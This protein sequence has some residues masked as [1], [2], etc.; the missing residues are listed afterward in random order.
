MGK[1][2]LFFSDVQKEEKEEERRNNKVEGC[3][4]QS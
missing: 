3:A 2:I 4:C 1:Y